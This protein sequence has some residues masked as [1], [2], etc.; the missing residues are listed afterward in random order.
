M[1]NPPTGP[2]QL[3]YHPI[4]LPQAPGHPPLLLTGLHRQE[5]REVTFLHRHDCLEIGWCLQGAG[6]FLIAD[7]VLPYGAGDVVAID[8]RSM[9]IARSVSG[10]E[11]LWRF[12]YVEPHRLLA[13]WAGL[14][15]APERMLAGEPDSVATP[16]SG[17]TALPLPARGAEPPGGLGIGAEASRYLGGAEAAGVRPLL[18]AVAE[19]WDQRGAHWRTAAAGLTQAILARL[20]RTATTAPTKDAKRTKRDAGGDRI[21][22]PAKARVLGDRAAPSPRMAAGAGG[23]GEMSGDSLIRIAPALGYIGQH[24]D[25]PCTAPDLAALCHMSERSFLRHFR[26]A[27]GVGPQAYWTGV[28]LRMAAALLRSTA[29]PVLTIATRVGFGSLSSFNRQFRARLGCTPTAWR[30]E[31]EP[32]SPA[33]HDSARC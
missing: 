10:T 21:P 11:S 24:L 8:P 23:G 14:D 26:A 20:A 29:E 9:H 32:E 25:E 6:V 4:A 27:V 3:H 15:G 18:E 28:R 33:E 1:Q 16:A 2:Y 7:Q 30:R 22:N 13:G 17:R 19:E 31:G 5:D 12:L